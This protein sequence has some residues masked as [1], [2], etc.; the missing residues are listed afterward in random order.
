MDPARGL[1]PHEFHSY[2]IADW[3]EARAM[4]QTLDGWIFRGS[5]HADVPLEATLIRAASKS[6]IHRGL[7]PQW[8]KLLL[9]QFQR[10]AHHY[11]PDLPRPDDIIEW[12]ALIQHHGGPTRLLDFSFSFYVAAF[13]AIEKAKRRPAAAVWAVSPAILT[14]CLVHHLG[15]DALARDPQAGDGY[16]GLLNAFLN[17]ERPPR[18][19]VIHAA[20]ERMNERL[21]IQQGLFLV[22][23]DL[24]TPFEQNLAATFDLDT[25]LF[26]ATRHERWNGSPL[27]PGTAIVKL[28]LPAAT[29]NEAL[30]DLYAMNVTSASLFP[31]LD[32]F[33]RSL[34]HEVRIWGAR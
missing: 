20:P 31:G 19:L 2:E 1:F 15:E 12:L 5:S 24:R 3:S 22:P 7:L 16:P 14:D 32:G 6:A 26:T 25:R 8:E 11:V 18:P 17:D 4:A 29:H 27:P 9:H 13:F 33:A 34:Y 21:S 28:R 10:R 30:R 23:C